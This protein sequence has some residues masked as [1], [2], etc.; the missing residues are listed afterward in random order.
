MSLTLEVVGEKAA[1]MGPAARKTFTSGGTIGRLDD[2]DWIFPDEYISGHHAQISFTNGA[3][4]IEDTSTNG[5][6]INSPQ[7]RLARNKPYALRSGDTI[8][9]DDYEVR[10]TVGAEPAAVE[11]YAPAR[12]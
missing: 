6:F 12:R 7:N 8:F 5:V 2:N 4:L 3:F 11:G 1:R 9:I 10:V